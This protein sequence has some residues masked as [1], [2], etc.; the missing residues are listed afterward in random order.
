MFYY[1][2]RI[3][4]T[5]K[6]KL[7]DSTISILNSNEVNLTFKKENKYELSG[8]LDLREDS[9]V[10]SCIEFEI[11]LQYC[12]LFIGTNHPTILDKSL[13]ILELFFN[14][15]VGGQLENFSPRMSKEHELICD[16]KDFDLKF[17]HDGEVVDEDSMENL[18]RKYCDGELDKDFILIEADVK[19][20][21]GS[22]FYYMR[23]ALKIDDKCSKNSVLNRFKKVMA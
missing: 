3:S 9:L 6:N 21:D 22:S 16:S 4:E 20:V 14:E 11:D 1:I 13:Q 10:N 8:F 19:L 18:G 17:I 15:T 7:Q 12:F 23:K 5:L 2:Y